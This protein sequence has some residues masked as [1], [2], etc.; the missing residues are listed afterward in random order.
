MLRQTRKNK[1]SEIE[2]WLKYCRRLREKYHVVLPEY[3]R[4]KRFVNS[5]YFTDVLSDLLPEDE[6]IVTGNGTAFTER[7]SVLR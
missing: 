3:K 7:Y 5:Y 4:D 6:V 2:E 1:F